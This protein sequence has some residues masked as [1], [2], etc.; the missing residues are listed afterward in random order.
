MDC[1]SGWNHWNCEKAPI[2]HAI[3]FLC[4]FRKP[5]RPPAESTHTR[6]LPDAYK[7]GLRAPAPPPA[8]RA[9]AAVPRSPVRTC[10]SF[11]C[12]SRVS[13][14]VFRFGDFKFERVTLR[15]NCA[16]RFRSRCR[17]AHGKSVNLWEEPWALVHSFECLHGGRWRPSGARAGD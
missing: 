1:I 2:P 5:R 11:T 10:V 16:R 14:W 3:Y 4:T 9:G 15:R 13:S 17:T 8:H 7:S 6:R 12:C